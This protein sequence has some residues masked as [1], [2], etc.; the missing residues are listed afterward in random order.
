MAKNL[1]PAVISA[2]DNNNIRVALLVKLVMDSNDENRI[3]RLTSLPTSLFWDEGE[4][5][6]KEY[7]GVGHLGSIS[8]SEET[9]DLSS[10]T[11]TVSLAGLPLDYT[12][13]SGPNNFYEDFLNVEYR[14]KPAYIYLAVLDDEGEIIGE[15]FTI[16]AGRSNSATIDIADTATINVEIASKLVDWERING[17]LFTHEHQQSYVDSTDLG[18]EHVVLMRDIEIRWGTEY[19]D[20]GEFNPIRQTR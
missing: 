15:P 12:T 6:E 8:S 3:I 11:I 2:L 18:F 13:A 7:I 4:S 20:A 19:G 1:L 17:K 14:N 9:A 10:V 16:F 5:A